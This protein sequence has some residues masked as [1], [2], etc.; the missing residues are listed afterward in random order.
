MRCRL[1]MWE[2][3]RGVDHLTHQHKHIYFTSILCGRGTFRFE[4]AQQRERLHA[5]T[6]VI[7]MSSTYEDDVVF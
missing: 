5:Y 2:F 6:A 1:L 3:E 4:L 7:S